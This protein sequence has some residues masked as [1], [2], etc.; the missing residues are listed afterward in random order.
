MSVLVAVFHSRAS[1]VLVLC[2]L[3][4]GACGGPGD[5]ATVSVGDGRDAG[6]PD[7]MN[8]NEPDPGCDMVEID[9]D[10]VIEREKSFTA[11]YRI[12]EPYTKTIMLFGGESVEGDDVL[13]NAY[14]LGLDKEDAL[15]LAELFHDFYLC[16]SPGGEEAAEHVFPYDLVPANCEVY[17]KLVRALNRFRINREAGGDR[18]SLR[19]EG[20]PLELES[21]TQNDNGADVTDQV[22]EQHFHLVTAVEQLTG[23]S[24]L[25]FGT[26][27]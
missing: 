20:A 17:E 6:D 27:D 16:S 2:G 23:E 5:G 4:C 13:S 12:G 25:E 22:T 14:I 21:V 1:V 15:M 11:R 24:V 7:D 18:T 3:L 10:F 19:L 9:G 26:T 8:M